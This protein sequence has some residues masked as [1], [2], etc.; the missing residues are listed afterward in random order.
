MQ[1]RFVNYATTGIDPGVE[2]Y[3]AQCVRLMYNTP[4]SDKMF[5]WF[6]II[7]KSVFLFLPFAMFFFNNLNVCSCI[8]GLYSF[9]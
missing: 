9:Q 7:F 8:F 6:V 3:I 1:S 5:I 4:I 2:A